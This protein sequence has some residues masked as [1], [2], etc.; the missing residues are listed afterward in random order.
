LESGT[1]DGLGFVF[2]ADDPYTGVDLDGVRD[3]ETGNLTPE[4]WAIVNALDGYTEVSPS[5]TG[6]HII[7]KGTLPVS[8]KRRGSIEAYSSGR[9]FTVTG[10]AISEACNIPERG[11]ALLSFY[12][13]HLEDK[14]KS[15][16]NSHYSARTAP[17]D[18]QEI[19]DRACRARNGDKF[20]RL[21][22]GDLSD[23]D[24]DHSAADEGFVWQLWF[25]TQNPEQIKRIH[26]QS[27]LSRHKSTR[28]R[29]Y[30]DRSI[31]NA[32][33]SGMETYEWGQQS[34]T[35]RRP[36]ILEAERTAD[37]SDGSDSFSDG[38][39][40]KSVQAFPT[41]VLP[42][43][44]ARYVEE[45]AASL[46]CPP[47]MVAIPAI[48]ALS[49]VMG[50]TREIRIKRGWTVSGSL[51]LAVVASA[52]EKKTPAQ[53]AAIFPVEKLQGTLRK[54]YKEEKN[55][56]EKQLRQHAADKRLASKE[57][58][59]EPEPPRHPVMRRCIVDDITIE[60]LA[61]R[62]E[63]NPRGFLSVQD[64]L[65]GF[66]RGMDQYKS[67]GK[68]N[69]RQSYLKIWSNGAIHVDRKGSDEPVVV[70]K[71]YVTLQGGIQ[72]AVLHEIADGRD[73]G[74]LDRF[75]FAYPTP[76]R[77]GWSYEEISAGTECAYE[78]LV[79]R[80][81]NRGA[82][83]QGRDG[84]IEPKV[85]QLDEEARRLFIAEVDNLAAERWAPGFPA[86]LS[87]PWSKMDTQ[88]AKLAL[89]LAVARSADEDSA[90]EYVSGDDMR[91]ALRLLEYF[92]ATTR[93][94][95]GQLFEADPDDVLAHDLAT[96]LADTGYVYQGTISNLMN[97]CSSEA[98]PE[99]PEALGK[100]IRRIAKR[101]PHL[102]LE[103][104]P[105][106]KERGIRI[107]LEKPVGTVEPSENHETE[108]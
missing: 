46:S 28:R 1:Y 39:S 83:T 6:A 19:I 25:W 51:Y 104:I 70:P 82:E 86:V 107:I 5:R 92:K 33:E 50:R 94:V 102:T 53:S 30:L 18:D 38:S 76:G 35:V 58:R 103:P 93:K 4:A 106:G 105:I 78:D 48:A 57:G 14:K 17:V 49:G 87:G 54:A 23:Y 24:G 42:S 98:M 13:E 45:A 81:W 68:G 22:R 3:R 8:G 12:R 62:L 67:G 64:E 32:S 77:G 73:D 60:A 63:E 71:P 66:L 9:Y 79:G 44:V 29:D 34:L 7:V 88:L 41:D 90:M 95:Y 56:Y 97:V 99:T 16:G 40:I 100:A 89:I 43:K 108:E 69:A 75:L 85:L 59:P 10:D 52:G 21:M 61:A 96:L 37:S 91:S 2:S 55:T 74:F 31:K 47:E 101:T 11:E 26:G 15:E 65:T 72:P 20:E 80:L 27:G 36:S 84:E